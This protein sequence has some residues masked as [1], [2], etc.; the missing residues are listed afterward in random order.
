MHGWHAMS[1]CIIF[2]RAHFLK[3]YDFCTCINY[4]VIMI[5][6]VDGGGLH[7]DNVTWLELKWP[8]CVYKSWKEF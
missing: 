4:G 1:F 3:A 2:P 7:D 6:R 5:A 8:F